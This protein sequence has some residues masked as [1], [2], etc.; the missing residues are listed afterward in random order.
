MLRVPSGRDD[1]LAQGRPRSVSRPRGAPPQGRS[2]CCFPRRRPRCSDTPAPCTDREFLVAVDLEERSERGLPLVRL[3]SGIEPEWLLDL[4]PERLRE[5]TTLEWNRERERVEEARVLLYDELAIEERRGPPSDA[6]GAPGCLP[7]ALWTQ[8]SA[9]FAEVGEVEQLLLRTG[10]AAQYSAAPAS[11]P[12]D[13][14]QGSCLALQRV[15]QLRRTRSRIRRR[16]TAA[17]VGTRSGRAA[18]R[19]C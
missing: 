2:N 9:R 18:L 7:N 14:K 1:A 8:A 5:R 6:E 10:F 16:G 15:P 17:R 13:A 3:A 4:F 12:Q 11:D 19:A